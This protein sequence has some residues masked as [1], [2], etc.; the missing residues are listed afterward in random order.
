[1]AEIKDLLE[2]IITA[3]LTKGI[4]VKRKCFFCEISE[5]ALENQHSH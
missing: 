5:C 4:T 1:M 2:V 3:S